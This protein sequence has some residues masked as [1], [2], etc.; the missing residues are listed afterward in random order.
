M[1][2]AKRIYAYAY[3]KTRD[4]QN[5]E[6]LSQEI[7]LAL[8]RSNTAHIENMDAYVYG[9][10]RHVWAR[11]LSRNKPHWEATRHTN[12]L[13]FLSDEKRVEEAVEQRAEYAVLRR[14]IAYLS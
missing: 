12:A 4:T 5:A 14:E 3:A 2:Y 1:K 9:I 10:C 8:L 13:D 6:D 11:Y 7:L